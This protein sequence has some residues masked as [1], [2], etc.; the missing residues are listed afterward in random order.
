MNAKTTTD[1]GSNDEQT[2]TYDLRVDADT[3]I[4][5]LK[6]NSRPGEERRVLFRSQA[7]G[8]YG[9]G[10]LRDVRGLMWDGEA[11]PQLRPQDF[12]REDLESPQEARLEARRVAEEEGDDPEAAEEV[13]MELW[14]D[15]ARGWLQDQIVVEPRFPEE[16]RT[17]YNIEY[18]SDDE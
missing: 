12:I 17:V 6:I 16:N 2:E 3:V 9:A 15:Q 10:V 13:A 4:Q 18:V 14:E 7:G 5:G 11:P 8:G 1:G